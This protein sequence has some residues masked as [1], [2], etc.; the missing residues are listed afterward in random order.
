MPFPGRHRSPARGAARW[1][2][3]VWLACCPAVFVVLGFASPAAAHFKLL[4]VVPA[5][6]TRVDAAIAEIR[7]TFSAPARPPRPA[8][9]APARV[10]PFR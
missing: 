8:S 2:L 7:L 3:L 10:R 4:K 1:V 6:G 9:G 5:D